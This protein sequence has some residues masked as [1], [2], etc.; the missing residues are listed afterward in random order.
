MGIV[1]KLQTEPA[2]DH[3]AEWVTRSAG[4]TGSMTDHSDDSFRHPEQD[5]QAWLSVGSVHR[6]T[7]FEPDHWQ[8]RD[9]VRVIQTQ[10][11][12]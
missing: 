12:P 6:W 10:H 1:S 3:M 11:P 4:H 9:R 7:Q 2:I 5:Q 8:S